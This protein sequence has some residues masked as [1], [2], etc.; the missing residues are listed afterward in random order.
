MKHKKILL[1][2]LFLTLGIPI[3]SKFA[4]ASGWT[5]S[6]VHFDVGAQVTSPTGIT[7]DGTNFWVVGYDTDEVY[8]YT[9]AGVYTGTSFDVGAQDTS[10]TGITWDGTNFWV[11]GYDTDEVYKYT[12]AGVYTGTSFDVGAQESLPKGITW[13]GTYFWV[14]G[15]ASDE[16]YKY[17]SAGVYT[18]INFDAGTE[19][20]T[21]AGITWDGTY[22]WVLERN[23]VYKHYSN[24][25]FTGTL[26]WAGNQDSNQRGIIWDGTYFWV[27]GQQLAVV[28]QYQYTSDEPEDII[29]WVLVGIIALIIVSATGGLATSYYLVKRQKKQK[30]VRK[31]QE[32]MLMKQK[33]K[34]EATVKEINML[35]RT[36]DIELSKG[37][38]SSALQKF[39]RSFKIADENRKLVSIILLNDIE[40]KIKLAKDKLHIEIENK[41]KISI[42]NGEKFESEN[43][44]EEAL[45]SYRAALEN[46]NDLPKSKER[47]QIIKNLKSKIDNV[48]SIKIGESKDRA[49]ELKNL[50]KPY[51]AIES[52]KMA[53]K[54]AENM[55]YP[56]QRNKE[57]EDI[58]Y[59][60]NQTYVD[61]LEPN[62]DKA[63]KLRDE[64]K[65]D[66]A[67]KNYNEAMQIAL[68]LTDKN[69][70][71]KK[72][73]DIR[74]YINEVKVAIIK[75]TILALG[76]KFGRLE[77][78]EV[79][80]ECGEDEELIVKTVKEMI[81]GN[82]IYAK[83]FDSSRAV[84]FNLQA[85]IDEIDSLM[86]KYKQ[87]EKEEKDKI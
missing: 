48:Y 75:S 55:Y 71:S 36:G 31:E 74:R 42:K 43:K 49:E 76:T 56:S 57:I 41:I 47:G 2:L 45:K 66:G 50:G 34:E 33:M 44:F 70:K 84:A 13:D 16:V 40:S 26:F 77:V 86:D 80:E 37:N 79:A 52:Y 63:H 8:K 12:S 72:V 39:N 53:I 32:I 6:G 15:R 83:Y 3:L 38:F 7:W 22:F 81:E 82:E 58:N 69:L 46:V 24:G 21:P 78:K 1:L 14:I 65:Y 10:P 85:N 28:Y 61:M 68:N 4:T 9:S 27:V 29:N 54:E 11:V 59:Y 62:I 23:R 18:G 17:T 51:N 30:R 5:Y 19:T 73:R 67:I 35:I 25:T 20:Y 64:F 87:W 60:I